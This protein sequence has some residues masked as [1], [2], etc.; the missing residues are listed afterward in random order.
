MLY[1]VLSQSFD[2]EIMETSIC[3]RRSVNIYIV[4]PTTQQGLKIRIYRI[5]DH[6]TSTY[7][8]IYL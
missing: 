3:A 5:T 8:N 1:T 2:E 7:N 4:S 6:H